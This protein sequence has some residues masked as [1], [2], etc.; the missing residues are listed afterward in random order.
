MDNIRIDNGYRRVDFGIY[1]GEDFP[2]VVGNAIKQ[3]YKTDLNN[4]KLIDNLEVT[5]NGKTYFVGKL[6]MLQSSSIQTDYNENRLSESAQVLFATAIWLNNTKNCRLISGLP[7]NYY[8]KYA[9]TL[10]NA[11][12]K[13]Y[14]ITINNETRKTNVNVVD[15]I[16]QPMAIFYDLIL[17]D[18]G[19]IEGYT[20]LESNGKKI[21]MDR[22]QLALSKMGIVDIG[23]GTTDICVINKMQFISTLSQSRAIAN[24]K[25]LSRMAELYYDEYQVEKSINDIED[26][27]ENGRLQYFRDIASSEVSSTLLSWINDVW[28]NKREYDFTILAGGGSYTMGNHFEDSLGA[29]RH[30]NPRKA[31]I[32]GYRKLQRRLYDE[33]WK[34]SGL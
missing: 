17:N 7:V 9:E 2:S 10:K 12:K 11:L 8:S 24:A 18:E 16:P 14:I 30:P 13:E 22:M 5:Y 32:M 15:I 33:A 27:V 3:K 4:N 21:P 19:K 31:V 6:A 29:Y 1:K 20:E 23:G 34:P 28:T 25:L 26:L